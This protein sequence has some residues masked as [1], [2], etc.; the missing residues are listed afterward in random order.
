MDVI[1]YD[2]LTFPRLAVNEDGSVVVCCESVIAGIESKVRWDESTVSYHLK[3]FTGVDS[4]RQHFFRGPAS[5]YVL[6]IEPFTPDVSQFRD[7]T[8]MIAFYS[9]EGGGVWT[10]PRQTEDFTHEQSQNAIEALFRA[11][12][13]DTMCRGGTE[14][15]DLSWTY[16]KVKGYFGW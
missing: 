11:V 4:E 6:A 16:E 1:V 13:E 10:S 5:Y 15:G 2:Y 8:R 7:T 3:R 14:I 9:L 12:L